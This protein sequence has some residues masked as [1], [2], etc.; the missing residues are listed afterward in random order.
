M[1]INI[2]MLVTKYHTQ[3]QQAHSRT[4]FDAKQQQWLAFSVITPYDKR[5]K[6]RSIVSAV[7]YLL[8]KERMLQRSHASSWAGF[9]GAVQG[10]RVSGFGG[11]RIAL[12]PFA[13]N[14]VLLA[15][16]DRDLQQALGHFPAECEAAGMKAMVLCR[17][18][19]DRS[20]RVGTE[21]LP[22]VKEFMYFVFL[23]HE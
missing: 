13:V 16:P 1:P 22:R 7:S 20:L 6:R 5:L 4:R 17:K 9:Q 3:Q 10:R 15:S 2:L 23:I 21:L 18:T 12:L 14:V 19:V 11:L 8:S